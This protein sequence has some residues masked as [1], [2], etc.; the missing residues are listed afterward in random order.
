MLKVSHSPAAGYYKL[1]Q[2]ERSL[3]QTEAAERDLGVFQTL[4]KNTS[5]GPYP[6][7]NLFDY[8]DNRS[9]LSAAQKTQQD[10]KELADQIEKHPDQPE[11]LYLLSRRVSETGPD[12]GSEE[13]DR[14]TGP[15]EPRRLPN[16]DRHRGLACAVSPVDEAIQHFEVAFKGNPDSD[17]VK[18]NLANAYFRKGLY[19]QAL[20]TVQQ[21]SPAEGRAG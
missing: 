10:L 7:Q 4:S 18:F 9:N 16:A 12:R 13:S 8:L 19:P 20:L 21:I 15:A 14:A 11:N 17:A 2:V 5:T 1:A 6:Y 3:H